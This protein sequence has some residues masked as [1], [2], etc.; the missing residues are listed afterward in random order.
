MKILFNILLFSSIGAQGLKSLDFE[1]GRRGDQ[2]RV[3]VYFDEKSKSKVADLDPVAIKRRIKHN[4]HSVTKYDYDIKKD[5]IKKLIEIG[6]EIKNQSRWL[7]AV[8]LIVNINE[9]ELIQKLSFVK[10]IEAVRQHK[11]KQAVQ[12]VHNRS[13][14]SRDIDYGMSYDQIEQ[15]NCRTPHIAGYYGQGVRVLYIDTGFEL[16][17][18]AYDSL[19]L[20]GQY[21]FINDDQNTANETAQEIL[22]NQDDHGTLCLS[23]MAGYAPGSLIGPAFKSEYLLAKT[24]IMA[25]EIQQEEDNYIAALEWGESLGADIAC[26]SLGY[27]DWYAYEDL[28]GNTAATTKAID[29]A[30]GLG[31]LCVNSAGNEGDDPWYY[32]ITPADAD[33]VLSIGAVD[34]NGSIA[35]FSSRGPTFDGR[36][37]PEVCARGVST[38]C[39]RSNT[40]NIYRNASG[41]SFSAP[42]AAGAAAVIMSA[43]PEWT[44]MQVREA[45]MMTASQFNNPDN[46]YGYGILNAW[47]AINYQF[48]TDVNNGIVF[49]NTISV[50]N[51]YPNPFNPRVSIEIDGLSIGQHV[52]VGVYDIHGALVKSLHNQKVGHN[53]LKLTWGAEMISS[54][55]YLLRTDW[56]YGND[57]QKI[58]L[59][60]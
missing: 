47:A 29:I 58:T 13:L 14:V 26:A 15:I 18:E 12:S 44:N 48:T 57:L 31:V 33:S 28:D 41:T 17:H 22:E 8:S 38:Y 6:A 55:I 60:K 1:A 16:N 32:I 54:G 51:A 50:N 7:N 5:Y 9:L 21:D 10:K 25:E 2:Y 45:I 39:I 34:V 23:V 43:N 30:S 53:V 37:K 24:E 36:I 46:E 40:E 20:V 59:L 42:L 52:A 3:W 56:Q 35:N 19:N 49:P 27:L 4:I 11:K